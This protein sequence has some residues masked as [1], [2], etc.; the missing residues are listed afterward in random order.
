MA[1]I[2]LSPL[3]VD[4]RA[5]QSDTVFSKWRGINY[6]RSRVIPANPKTSAQQAVRQALARLVS[7]WQG[8]HYSMRV[9][10]NG[11]ATGLPKS[12]F[13]T[14]IGD[15]LVD[16]KEGNL[17]DLT[18]DLGFHKLSNFSASTG[19]GSGEIDIS[20]SPDASGTKR[21]VVL[22]RKQGADSWAA[23]K[24]YTLGNSAT[25]TGLEAGATYQ[26]YA[27]FDANK[28]ADEIKAEEVGDDMSDT[29]TAGS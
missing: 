17:L 13:N 14:F 24:T 4:I 11:Y 28:T 12:G 8:A 22:V 20:W 16:E 6:I 26:V 2:F 7:L 29:A 18:K 9:N 19:S 1:R 10:R 21:L 3:I 27:F 15:N 23:I 5:K 25:I